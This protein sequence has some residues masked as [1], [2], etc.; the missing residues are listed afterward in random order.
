MRTERDT[1][2]IVRSWLSVEEHESADRVLDLVLDRLDTTPQRR[3]SR[4]TARSLFGINR[5]VATGIAAGLVAIAA[6]WGIGLLAPGGPGF[7][8]PALD[9]SP[10]PTPS[11]MAWPTSENAALR[12]GTYVSEAPSPAGSIITLPEGWSAC[13][14]G[15]EE[16][17]ACA[18]PGGRRAVSVSIVSNV[19]ADPCHGSRALLDPRV[20][21]SVDDLVSAISNLSGFVATAPIDIDIDGRAG[22]E[23]ELTAPTGPACVDDNTGLATWTTS[24]GI[25]VVGPGEVNLLRIVEVDGVRV[26]IAAAY[27]PSASAAEITELRA[28]FDSIQLAP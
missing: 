28:I 13:G 15:S 23:F 14:V 2:R 19:V 22:K 11:P 7:G 25:N 12:A 1:A 21:D 5:M 9:S 20:G 8:G 3:L 26:M 18:H 27:Q 6:I 17:A 10:T 4:W 24:W 16:L